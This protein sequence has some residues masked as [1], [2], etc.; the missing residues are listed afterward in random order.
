MIQVRLFIVA[1]VLMVYSTRISLVVSIFSLAGP[2]PF[3]VWYDIIL[4]S[5]YWSLNCGL[6]STVC[7]SGSHISII[8]IPLL[9]FSAY[10]CVLVI[11]G[12]LVFLMTLFARMREILVFTVSC[13]IDNHIFH[14]EKLR[15][16]MNINVLRR[17]YSI[18]LL[19]ANFDILCI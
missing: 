16:T 15:C 12:L 7:V 6:Y 13:L 5:W 14:R 1:S 17:I 8:K 4:S 2:T 9:K 19:N 18:S 3:L 11:F 10:V